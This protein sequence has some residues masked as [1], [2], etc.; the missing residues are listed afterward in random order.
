M[1]LAIVPRAIYTVENC[2]VA[3]QLN[4]SLT[5]FWNQSPPRPESWLEALRTKTEQDGVRILEHRV[6]QSNS[7]QFLLSTKPNVSP[8]TAIRSVKGRLQYLVRSTLP[9][10]FRR[11]YSIHSVGSANVDAIQRY[12][13]SQIEHHPL[14]DPRMQEKIARFQYIDEGVDLSVVRRSSYGEFIYDLHLVLV[15]SERLAD[16]REESWHLTRNTIRRIAN[17][18]GHLLSRAGLLVDHVHSAIGCDVKDSPEDI[19]MSYLNNLSYVHEM[20]ALYQFGYYVGTFGPYDL[21][22]I[23]RS[24]RK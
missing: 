13:D 4:W 1:T 7:S 19:A 8:A 24:F 2:K 23:R 20:K 12:V 9:Q 14:A 17:K 6:L 16:V 10:A 5:I 22:A 11:N 18:K 21:D 15:H 3:Y